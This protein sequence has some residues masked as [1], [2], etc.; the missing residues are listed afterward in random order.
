MIICRPRAERSRLCRERRARAFA[1]PTLA[2]R[3]DQ[4]VVM[5]MNLKNDGGPDPKRGV[6]PERWLQAYEDVLAPLEPDVVAVTEFTHSQSRRIAPWAADRRAANRRFKAAQQVLHMRGFRARMGQGRNPTG[7]FVREGS[8]ILGQSP[9]R[10]LH[11]VYRTPPTHVV[12][13]LPEVPHVP[14]NLLSDHAP[15]CNPLLNQLEAY[16]LTSVVDKVDAHRDISPDL[17]GA[18]AWI[19]GDWNQEPWRQSDIDWSSPAVTDRVHRC[20]RAV[21]QSG[22]PNGLW[23]SR[24]GVDE[25][26]M[27]AGMHDAC[28]FAA[29]HRG[30]HNALD[31]TA[32][33]APGVA[34]QGGLCRIDRPYMDGFS[35]RAV[36]EAWVLDMTGISDHHAV[37]IVL[38][39]PRLVRALHR[40]FPELEPWELAA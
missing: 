5:L 18:A 37:V 3:E 33:L 19:L 28:R 1:G 17:E 40:E 29:L 30:Q 13:R 14:I 25:L 32:G 39:R 31:P 22:G 20:H 16:E 12:A 24:T 34:G 21:K 26:M 4:L 8:F 7:M 15:Y 11:R 38:S 6:L 36:E 27:D 35:V 23:V 9:Q 10:H 2:K